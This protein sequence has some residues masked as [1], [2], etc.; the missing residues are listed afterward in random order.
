MTKRYIRFK[1][2]YISLIISEID[3][4]RENN[5]GRKGGNGAVVA[6]LLGKALMLNL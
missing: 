2:F 3:F 6:S 1:A 5:K 4:S